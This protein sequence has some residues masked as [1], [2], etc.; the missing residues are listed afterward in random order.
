MPTFLLRFK[1]EEHAL[2]KKCAQA[3]DKSL[4]K[5][6]SHAHIEK[7]LRQTGQ[8]VVPGTL[9]KIDSQKRKGDRTA[10]SR[11]KV[12]DRLFNK[13]GFSA[14]E[15]LLLVTAIGVIL[16]VFSSCRQ[17]SPPSGPVSSSHGQP[18]NR[19]QTVTIDGCEYLEASGG[20][21]YALTHKGNCQNPIHQHAR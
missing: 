15:V 12:I 17:E 19:V 21:W 16:G 1:K 6:L 14:L 4:H 2:Y 8:A 10:N 11:G 18:I 13:K 20:H 5:W 9:M 7:A 3:E